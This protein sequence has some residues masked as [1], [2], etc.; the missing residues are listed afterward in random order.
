MGGGW[1][2]LAKESTLPP[3][4]AGGLKRPALLLAGIVLC[5]G[6]RFCVHLTFL[7][8]PYNRPRLYLAHDPSHSSER[9]ADSALL[10]HITLP[11]IGT[12]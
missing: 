5:A 2:L 1:F 12:R 11:Q 3:S 10:K 8:S 7:D 9:N 4:A 6:F